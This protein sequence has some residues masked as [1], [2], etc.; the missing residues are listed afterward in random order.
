M[1]VRL[2]ILLVAV[3]VIFGGTFLVVRFTQTPERTPE[4]QWMYKVDEEDVIH[5][6]VSYNGKTVEYDKKPGSDE[7]VIVGNPPA[8]VFLKKWGGTT[9]LLSGPQVSRVLAQEIDNPATYGLEPPVSRVVVTVRGGLVYEFHIGNPTPDGQNQYARLVGDP[10][11]FTV[12]EI[13]ARVINNLATEPPYPV[14]EGEAKPG[15]G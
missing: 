3:L 13:W 15:A 6:L 14:A 9:L 4:K 12:A 8:P 2:S 7:W 11:L 10:E 5:I 1:N